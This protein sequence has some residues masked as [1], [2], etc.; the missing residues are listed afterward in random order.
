VKAEATNEKWADTLRKVLLNTQVAATSD[1]RELQVAAGNAIKEHRQS[2]KKS[3]KAALSAAT[4]D[5][6]E[7]HMATADALD[8]VSTAIQTMEKSHV[9]AEAMRSYERK[10]KR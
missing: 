2:V 5:L 8:R 7:H 10:G 4:R 9:T 3:L 1:M 6:R